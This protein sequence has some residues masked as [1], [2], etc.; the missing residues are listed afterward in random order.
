MQY[1]LSE[2]FFNNFKIFGVPATTKVL[3]EKIPI[4][5]CLNA[6]QFVP[7]LYFEVGN[8]TEISFERE[9][10]VFLKAINILS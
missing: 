3:S 2:V 4:I 5:S 10:S 9:I 1:E 8:A 7:V 6:T